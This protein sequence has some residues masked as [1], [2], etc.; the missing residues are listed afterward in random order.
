MKRINFF[1]I[2]IVAVIG[3]LVMLLPSEGTAA[4]VTAEQENI[5]RLLALSHVDLIVK[6]IVT[7]TMKK[8]EFSFPQV[9]PDE[10]QAFMEQI[11]TDRAAED[12]LVPIYETHFSPSE[13]EELVK[14]YESPVGKKLMDLQP[15]IMQEA[16]DAINP[17][18]DNLAREFIKQLD[19]SF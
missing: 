13:I 3:L 19:A 1:I 17:W 8:L 15:Q 16:I 12:I 6:D 7:E 14:F 10:I 5:K 11:D 18:G 9:A 4:Q 2:S